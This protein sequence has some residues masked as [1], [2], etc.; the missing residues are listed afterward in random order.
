MGITKKKAVTVNI[1]ISFTFS[2]NG[3]LHIQGVPT[4]FP[5]LQVL[6]IIW[7]KNVL[8]K[9][10]S[11]FDWLYTVQWKEVSKKFSLDNCLGLVSLNNTLYFW[12]IYYSIV[13]RI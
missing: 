1:K 10:W 8:N 9:S 3:I 12:F 5:T 11:V 2:N 6:A 7:Q 13:A 4:L